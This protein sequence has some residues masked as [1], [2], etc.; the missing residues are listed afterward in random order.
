[1][2]F[3]TLRDIIN[4]GGAHFTNQTMKNLLTKY[5]VRQKVATVN[6]PQTTGHVEVS[7]REVKQI[8]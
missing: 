8:L 5:G 7:N 3:G 6:H 4:D 2:R 1:M